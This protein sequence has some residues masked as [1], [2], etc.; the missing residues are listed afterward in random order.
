MNA[1]ARPID[2]PI[3]ITRK[4]LV[5]ASPKWNCPVITAAN[6][7]RN[8]INDEASFKRLSP[9]AM[10]TRLFGA[11]TCRIMV[12]AE[13]ASGGDTIPPKRKPNANVNPGIRRYDANATTQDVI[14]TIGNAKL[15][16]TRRYFQNCFHD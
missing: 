14:I 10:L 1:T 12:D 3:T 9:S 8:T 4:K 2:I 15:M 7:K 6:A 11:F 13:I 5:V 16:I